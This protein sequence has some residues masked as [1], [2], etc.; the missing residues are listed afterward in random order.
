VIREFIAEALALSRGDYYLPNLDPEDFTEE[1]VTSWLEFRWRDAVPAR[2]LARFL[3]R[4]RFE[5]EE[6]EKDGETDDE[7]EEET[8]A[9]S[10]AAP[11]RQRS[12]RI[13]ERCTRQRRV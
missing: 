4:W 3:A 2:H 6:K 5:E 8:P 1:N 13:L 7:D 12:P 11:R 9:S 10:S